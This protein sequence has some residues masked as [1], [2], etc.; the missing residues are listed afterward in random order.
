MQGLAVSARCWGCCRACWRRCFRLEAYHQP[1]DEQDEEDIERQA[2]ATAEEEQQQLAN[3]ARVTAEEQQVAEQ[4]ERERLQLGSSWQH[5]RD[6]HAQ[7]AW[8]EQSLNASS[9]P[10]LQS[11]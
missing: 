4:R 8:F 7:G 3:V 9:P 5:R 10:A 6:Q 1:E 11:Q 2:A